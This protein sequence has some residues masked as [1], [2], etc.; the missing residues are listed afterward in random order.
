MKSLHVIF[1]GERN[2]LKALHRSYAA[3]D[4]SVTG[5]RGDGQR[6]VRVSRDDASARGFSIPN[7]T[8]KLRLTASWRISWCVADPFLAWIVRP[9][10]GA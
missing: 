9:R 6:A 10:D 5:G 8:H 2:F 4:A 7:R 1:P 3:L